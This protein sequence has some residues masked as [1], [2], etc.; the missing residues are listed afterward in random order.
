MT[1]RYAPFDEDNIHKQMDLKFNIAEE[2]K[3]SEKNRK[4]LRQ[5]AEVYYKL[6]AQIPFIA[7]QLSILRIQKGHPCLRSVFVNSIVSSLTLKELQFCFDWK[8]GPR[9][10]LEKILTQNRSVTK[11][12]LQVDHYDNDLSLITF[13]RSNDFIKNLTLELVFTDGVILENS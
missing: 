8:A 11:L 13:F 9:T 3:Q 7:N 2:S 10:A 5:Y 1:D 12:E 4:E 6:N